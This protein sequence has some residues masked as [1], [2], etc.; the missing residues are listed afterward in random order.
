MLI[1]IFYIK[2]LQFIC[3]NIKTRQVGRIIFKKMIKINAF[4]IG[5]QCFDFV[6]SFIKMLYITFIQTKKC[7]ML[8]LFKRK[9]VVNYIF[10]NEKVYIA[11]LKIKKSWKEICLMD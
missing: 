6:F 8:H 10:S 4:S 5:Y 7:C 11:A 2:T 9:N 3:Q 1:K